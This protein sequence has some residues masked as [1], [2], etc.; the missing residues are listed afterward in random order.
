M[1]VSALQN[2]ITRLDQAESKKQALQAYL[3]CLPAFFPAAENFEPTE[4]EMYG[5]AREENQP[6]TDLK[7]LRMEGFPIKGETLL[8]DFNVCLA[9]PEGSFQPGDLDKLRVLSR[10][11]ELTLIRLQE[12]LDPVTGL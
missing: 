6:L 1:E 9:G 3:E 7:A 11:Y 4:D 12:G 10:Y 2:L 5:L 8:L